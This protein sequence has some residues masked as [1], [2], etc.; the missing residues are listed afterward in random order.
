LIVNHC[1]SPIER[2]EDDL[3][4]WRKDMSLLAR[5]ENVAVKISALGTYDPSP[6]VDSFRGI[7]D[8]LVQAFGPNRCMFASDFPVGSLQL[9]FNDIYSKFRDVAAD[10][11]LD[12]QRLLFFDTARNIYRFGE[13]VPIA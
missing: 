6:S 8:P 9:S 4:S 1:G 2:S 13:D 10:Y 11:E 5:C 7:I 12:E 3:E